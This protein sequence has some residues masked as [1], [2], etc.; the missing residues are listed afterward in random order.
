MQEDPKRRSCISQ[1]VREGDVVGNVCMCGGEEGENMHG[2]RVKYACG[3]GRHMPG[4]E[5][6]LCLY[7]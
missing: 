7:L 2:R 3:G 4:E 1:V 6:E 5:D